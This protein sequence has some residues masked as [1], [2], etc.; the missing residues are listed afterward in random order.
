MLV[1]IGLHE[2]KDNKAY[3]KCVC[4]CGKTAYAETSNLTSGN[5]RSCGCLKTNY[6]DL[7]G[8]VFGDLFVINR[9]QTDDKKVH[10]N[11]LC[12]CG[13][14]IAARSDALLNGRTHSCGC[15]NQSL[16]CQNIAS[17]LSDNGVR[18]SKEVCFGDLKSPK[19]VSLRYDFAIHDKNGCIVRL[20]EYDGRQHVRAIQGWWGGEEGLAYRKQCD[21][22]KTSYALSHH[23]PLVR[24]PYTAGYNISMED[25]F[26]DKYIDKVA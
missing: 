16:A 26:G 5:T 8:S 17:M 14:H 15:S 13:N 6:D 22:I 25:I 1:V 11:C 3:W 9:I 21:S 24:I 19:G 4:D 7:S 20:V 23:I 2:F 18:F 12:K 10:Y